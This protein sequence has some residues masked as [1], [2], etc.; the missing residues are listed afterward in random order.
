MRIPQTPVP[1]KINYEPGMVVHACNPSYL[2]G[3]EHENQDSRS[4]QAKVSKTFNKKP[5]LRA[6]DTA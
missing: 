3:R 4:A 5:K 2:G 1:S 6:G